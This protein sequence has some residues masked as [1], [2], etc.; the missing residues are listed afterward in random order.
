MRVAGFVEP[1]PGIEPTASHIAELIDL[2]RSRRIRVIGKEP[3]FSVNAPKTIAAATGAR[4]IDLPP[5]VGGA[6]GTG[7]YFSLFDVLLARLSS[8]AGGRP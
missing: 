1:K 8:A 3:Y 6:E 5:S 4:I 7:D 2:M